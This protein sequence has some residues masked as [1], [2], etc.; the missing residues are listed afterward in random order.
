MFKP[1][2]NGVSLLELLIILS[3]IAIIDG[4]SFASYA[5]FIERQRLKSAGEVVFSHLRLAQSESI[6]RSK[7]IYVDF[8]T[9]EN[10]WCYGISVDKNCDCRELNNCQIDNV[11]KVTSNKNFRGITLQKAK[12]AGNKEYTAFNPVKGFAQADGVKNGTIWLQSSDGSQL[13]VIVNRLGRIRFCSP[14]LSGYS[15]QCPATP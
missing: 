8:K 2:N 5:N 3:V 9:Y 7:T 1:I 14:T 10:G 13:A 11:N 4:Y 15:R 12:F 6:K